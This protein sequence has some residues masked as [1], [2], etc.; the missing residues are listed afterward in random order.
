MNRVDELIVLADSSKFEGPSGNVACSL[1]DI[2]IVVTDD[3][4]SEKSVRM[5]DGAGVKLILAR[6]STYRRR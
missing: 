6:G 4:I 2:D 1:T 3:A 5:L